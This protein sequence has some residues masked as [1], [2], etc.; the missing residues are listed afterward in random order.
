MSGTP[1]LKTL[2]QETNLGKGEYFNNHKGTA[3]Q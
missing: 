3:R 2:L 1:L